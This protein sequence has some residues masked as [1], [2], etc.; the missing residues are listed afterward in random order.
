M[1]IFEE[2]TENKL[3][4]LVEKA[5]DAEK[6]FKKA[7]ENV[8][9]ARLKNFF[10]HKANERGQ[11]RS[12][13][14]TELKSMGLEVNEDDGSVA[15][16]IHRTWMDTKALFST[17]NEESMLEEVRNGEKAALSDYEDILEDKKLPPTTA[18][19][20]RQQH[21]AIKKSH[22]TADYLEDIR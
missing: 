22:D 8:S 10:I 18:N 6:G 1:G 4:D 7:A 12:E 17:D 14:K 15:G 5:Y 2:S 16:A 11:F 3:N 9:D 20:L 21:Q 13:L 19:V